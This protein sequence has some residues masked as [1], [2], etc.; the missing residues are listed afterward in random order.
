ME[1]QKQISLLQGKEVE[2]IMLACFFTYQ[3]IEQPYGLIHGF[4]LS[5]VHT[6]L[7]PQKAFGGVTSDIN[8]QEG[9]SSQTQKING[10]LEEQLLPLQLGFLWK[11]LFIKK[12]K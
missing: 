1:T 11:H 6:I 8:G 5:L 7:K 2:G 12:V 3:S 10:A 4:I 9:Y